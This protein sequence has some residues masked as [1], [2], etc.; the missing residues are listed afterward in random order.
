MCYIE[1]AELDGLDNL[2]NISSTNS[3][4]GETN[5]KTRSAL[6]ET[7]SLGII[8]FLILLIYYLAKVQNRIVIICYKYKYTS[9]YS[10]TH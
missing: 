2:G 1:T 4:S 8:R 9:H 7:A 5:L 10:Y 6:P 3:Q